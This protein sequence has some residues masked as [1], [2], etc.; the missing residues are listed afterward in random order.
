MFKLKDGQ[1]HYREADAEKTKAALKV[2]AREMWDLYD[3]KIAN[4]TSAERYMLQSDFLHAY[5]GAGENA[6]AK[7]WMIK[8]LFDEF[9]EKFGDHAVLHMSVVHT[10][11]PFGIQ[12][13][14]RNN[15]RSSRNPAYH[16]VPDDLT[17]RLKWTNK[18]LFTKEQGG[19]I[20]LNEEHVVNI[21]LDANNNVVIR[22]TQLE[23]HGDTFRNCLYDSGIF[24][25]YE[26]GIHRKRLVS[27]DEKTPQQSGG[28]GCTIM[29]MFNARCCQDVYPTIE[30]INNLRLLFFRNVYNR[31]S[32]S[33]STPMDIAGDEWMHFRLGLFSAH[34]TSRCTPWYA[35][36]CTKFCEDEEL[37]RLK[38]E[39]IM[40]VQCAETQRRIELQLKPLPAFEGESLSK[41]G[42][43]RFTQEYSLYL[44]AYGHHE[45]AEDLIKKEVKNDIA[46]WR[47]KTKYLRF[48]N[49]VNLEDWLMQ[50]G[51][52]ERKALLFNALLYEEW[53]EKHER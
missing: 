45:D 34:G 25:V 39:Y 48:S 12:L 15:E 2:L 17:K 8:M 44:K 38:N 1:Q 21:R 53:L 30:D 28:G 10:E 14:R 26:S 40:T 37:Q 22:E 3:E 35:E 52:S 19:F 24:D 13:D 51:D 43:G 33:G 31:L 20:F 11:E 50:Q 42:T 9:Q 32:A 47:E 7:Y 6:V 18:H 46:T 49:S 4:S 29:A 27:C 5:K 23:E 41:H 36:T 16:F